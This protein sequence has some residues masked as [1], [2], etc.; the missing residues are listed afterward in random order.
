MDIQTLDIQ[1][2]DLGTLDLQ[3]VSKR[4]FNFGFVNSVDKKAA[5]VNVL[6]TPS[7]NPGYANLGFTNLE[8][9]NSDIQT[10]DIQHLNLQKLECTTLEYIHVHLALLGVSIEN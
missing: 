10:L 7:T 4:L 8:Y 2:L 3:D 1:T 6:E 9:K 5:S